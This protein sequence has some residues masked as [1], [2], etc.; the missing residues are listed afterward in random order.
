MAFQHEADRPLPAKV[1]PAVPDAQGWVVEP[2]SRGDPA[3]EQMRVFTG[4]SALHQ[5]LE[6]ACRTYGAVSYFCR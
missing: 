6:Y 1:Y 5:A 3:E 2:P 4:K